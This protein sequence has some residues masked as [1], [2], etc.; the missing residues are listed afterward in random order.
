MART[1]NQDA[2]EYMELVAN[3][4]AYAIEKLEISQS[5]LADLIKNNKQSVSNAAISKL[6]SKKKE[7]LSLYTVAVVAEALGLDMN[8]LCSTRNVRKE[9]LA[10]E[11]DRYKIKLP[12]KNP[13]FIC[14]LKSG[15]F[16][17][18]INPEGYDIF[19][20]RTIADE[21]GYIG[22]KLKIIEDI[23]LNRVKVVIDLS[24]EK[25]YTPGSFVNKHYEGALK[26][27]EDMHVLYVTATDDTRGEE[28]YLIF[29]YMTLQ[30]EPLYCSIGMSLVSC[31]GVNKLPTA[32]R[33]IITRK[34]I[35]DR[36]KEM[37]SSQL[38]LNESDIRISETKFKR[39]LEDKALPE[40]FRAMFLPDGEF[41][42]ALKQTYYWINETTIRKSELNL[43]DQLISVCVL[44]K[45]SESQKYAKVSNKANVLLYRLLK[46]IENDPGF[47]DLPDG[48]S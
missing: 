23:I 16:D 32:H 12:Q 31:A 38:L 19:M 41:R 43:M 17:K 1:K 45:Y 46:K 48:E 39:L 8:E 35:P 27:S 25:N 22:G 47:C 33:I 3:R 24:V 36:W 4:L 40:S 20:F 42:G 21:E 44:R 30:E 14:D 9:A 7:G 29:P 5:D 34:Q 37:I 15:K 11:K 28:V 6:Y 18:Y 10:D 2:N 13:K 26:Y